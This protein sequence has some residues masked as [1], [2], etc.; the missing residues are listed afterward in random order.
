MYD[1][2]S[3]LGVGVSRVVSHV[4]AAGAVT[5]FA[6]HAQEHVF[7]LVLVFGAGYMFDPGVV[8]LKAAS[9]GV[10]RQILVAERVE[11]AAAPAAERVDPGD[12]Q[13]VGLVAVPGKIH[14]IRSAAAAV[15]QTDLGVE[16]LLSRGRLADVRLKELV[17]LLGVFESH[18]R[19]ADD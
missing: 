7:A 6:G 14:L 17:A 12:G 4:I 8:A 1:G 11:G 18:G 10:T 16:A 2:V 13:L 15:H 5:L 3:G 19:V 9:R